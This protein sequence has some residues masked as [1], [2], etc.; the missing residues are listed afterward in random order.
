MERVERRNGD[1]KNRE[2][3]GEEERYWRGGRGEYVVE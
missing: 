2:I 1:E 3:G